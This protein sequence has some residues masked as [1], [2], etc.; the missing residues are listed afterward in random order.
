MTRFSGLFGKEKI[1]L[2]AALHKW[3]MYLKSFQRG[4]KILFPNYYGMAH[5][6]HHLRFTPAL[7]VLEWFFD[8]DTCIVMM[9]YQSIKLV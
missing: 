2:V 8:A 6:K 7:D 3:F 4:K 1:H 9:L 5:Y